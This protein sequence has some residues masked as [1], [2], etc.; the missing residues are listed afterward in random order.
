[1]FRAAPFRGGFFFESEVRRRKT[2]DFSQGCK[3]K[4]LSEYLPTSV[5]GLPTNKRF[6]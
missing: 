6:P 3:R 1:M 4:L 5:F 2:E